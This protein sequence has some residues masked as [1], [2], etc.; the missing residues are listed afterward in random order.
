MCVPLDTYPSPHLSNKI[1]IQ[2]GQCDKTRKVQYYQRHQL[3]HKI[4]KETQVS[5]SIAPQ[6]PYVERCMHHFGG[7][8]LVPQCASFEGTVSTGPPP[9]KVKTCFSHI[10]GW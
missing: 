3:S 1:G 2:I 8:I 5:T 9:K 4:S 7:N 10:S 6:L